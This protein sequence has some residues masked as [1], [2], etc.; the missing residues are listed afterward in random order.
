M[1]T[2]ERSGIVSLTAAGRIRY[3]IDDT[4]LSRHLQNVPKGGEDC[5]FCRRGPVGVRLIEVDHIGPEVSRSNGS[6]V[7]ASEPLY[8]A[9]IVVIEAPLHRLI[10]SD[11]PIA[12]IS[13]LLLLLNQTEGIGFE[14]ELLLRRCLLFEEGYSEVLR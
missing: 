11:T 10:G 6:D 14:G 2:E 13:G 4:I 3:P 1:E 12:L 5:V 7:S 8:E 9:P